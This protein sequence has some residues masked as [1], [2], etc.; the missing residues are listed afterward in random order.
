MMKKS[1]EAGRTPNK[2]DVALACASASDAG[3][4]AYTRASWPRPSALRFSRSRNAS[5]AST[6]SAFHASYT[7]VLY[8]GSG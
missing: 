8:V 2:L 7:G 4:S 1:R 5:A 6:G 3:P